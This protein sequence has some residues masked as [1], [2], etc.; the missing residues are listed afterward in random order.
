MR[1]GPGGSLDLVSDRD[2]PP[3][4]QNAYP[5]LYQIPEN[6]YPKISQ[7]INSYTAIYA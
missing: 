5:Y 6:V 3:K 2:V 4:N 1:V 7:N